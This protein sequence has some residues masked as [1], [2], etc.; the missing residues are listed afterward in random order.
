MSR[1][2]QPRRPHQRASG[3]SP[4]QRS[5]S[6]SHAA[7]GAS[8][9]RTAG[10]GPASAEGTPA[11]AGARPVSAQHTATLVFRRLSARWPATSF[12]VKV[13]DET[14]SVSDQ[15]HV[16]RPLEGLT[17]EWSD[18]PSIDEVD[19]S[20]ACFLGVEVDSGT[21]RLRLR[22]GLLATPSRAVVLVQYLVGY[23]S[24]HRRLSSS[25]RRELR[26]CAR[27]LRAHGAALLSTQSAGV[28]STAE[29]GGTGA[30]EEG[31]AAKRR[32]EQSAPLSGLSTL[33]VALLRLPEST[34]TP[35]GIHRG[36]TTDL[37]ELLSRHISFEDARTLAACDQRTRVTLLQLL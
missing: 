4:A 32:L 10:D 20:V 17:V 19:A 37:L 29:A 30:G 1:P 23:I 13:G 15:M 26:T 36:P 3:S 14:I 11:L 5:D 28:P 34:W 25:Y 31:A 33:E 27:S 12:R 8:H 35:W 7:D 6:A 9:A 21:H 18:G 16:Q 22:E 24:A 2:Q